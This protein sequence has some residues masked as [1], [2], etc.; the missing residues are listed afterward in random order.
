MNN[1]IP[2]S[3]L[4]MTPADMD[5]LT[6]LLNESGTKEEQRMAWYGAMLALNLAHMLHEKSLMKGNSMKINISDFV[7]TKD[8]TISGQVME[9]I[10]NRAVIIDD[11]SEYEYPENCLEFQDFGLATLV[12]TRK[13]VLKINNLQLLKTP[14]IFWLTKNTRFAIIYV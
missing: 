10:D 6:R 4:W 5:H 1:P 3:N 14:R 11:A 13:K 7:T 9:I 8:K 2:H 12:D